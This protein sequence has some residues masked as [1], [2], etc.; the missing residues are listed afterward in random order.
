MESFAD[1]VRDEPLGV[2]AFATLLEAT[3]LA[4]A[5]RMDHN[6]YRP[7]SAL[8]YQPSILRCRVGPTPDRNHVRA[9]TGIGGQVTPGR[10]WV[11]L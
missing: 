5:Y 2:E 8:G 11:P 6:T 7:H 3:T 1:K 4:E 9:G 10:S